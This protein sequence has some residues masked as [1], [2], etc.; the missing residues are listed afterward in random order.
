MSEGVETPLVKTPSTAEADPTQAAPVAAEGVP[1]VDSAALQKKARRGMIA[2]AI[3]M[4][5]TQLTVLGGDVYLRRRLEPSDFGIFAVVQFALL[6]FMQLGDVGLASALIQQREEPTQRQLGSAWTFQLLV[7]LAF[8]TALWVGAP[9]LVDFWHDMSPQSI[10]VFRAL[11][12]DL[13]LTSLR[14]VPSLL[15]ERRLEYG[16]LSTLDVILNGTYYVTAV[17]FATLGFGVMSLAGAVLIQGLGGVVGAFVM[18]PWRP[19]LVLD[20]AALRPIVRFGVQFQVKN[21]VGFLSSAIAPV[22]AGR[23]LG[24]KQLGYITWGQTTAFFPLR[25]VE[26]MS[27]VSFPLYSRLRFDRDAFGRSLERAVV[28]SA[29]GTLFFVALSLGLGPNLVRVVYGEKWVPAL[30]LFYIYAAGFTVGF[31]HP[32]VAPALDALGKPHVNMRLMIGWTVAIAIL[33]AITT[34][35]WGAVGFAIGACIPMVLGNFV[36]IVILKGLIPERRL[37]P[38]IRALLLGAVVTGLVDRFALAPVANGVVSFTLAVLASAAL[39]LTV[40]GIF[41]RSAIHEIVELAGLQKI[42]KK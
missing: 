26:I 36:V 41:D 4:V 23:V 30:P 18:C 8:T 14:L 31:L 35:I 37:W 42:L 7:S 27:R 16:K 1:H 29:M 28:V 22:Y 24:Q 15:M 25:L 9:L 3:R 33:V 13:L 5:L 17:T 12:V 11:S 34:P 32:V 20:R 2:L 40:V 21:A 6:L 19:S 10:W 38:R 39:F